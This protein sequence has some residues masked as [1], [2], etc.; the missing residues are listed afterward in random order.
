MNFKFTVVGLDHK[1]VV[2][3]C[4]KLGMARETF[5]GRQEICSNKLEGEFLGEIQDSS[6]NPHGEFSEMRGEKGLAEKRELPCWW[7]AD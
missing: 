7:L 2:A 4:V 5:R 1:I 6:T 3:S